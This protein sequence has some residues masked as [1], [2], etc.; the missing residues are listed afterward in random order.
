MGI[1][2]FSVLAL[3]SN[4]QTPAKS[5]TAA[6]AQ[7][8]RSTSTEITYQLVQTGLV[9][10]VPAAKNWRARRLQITPAGQAAYAQEKARVEQLSQYFCDLLT[11]PEQTGLHQVLNVLNTE[12]FTQ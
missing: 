4:G 11:A 7:L 9:V 3:V 6:N 12:H 8:E 1:R 2:E 10:G 5:K